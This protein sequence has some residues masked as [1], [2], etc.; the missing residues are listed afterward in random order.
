[1]QVG[2]NLR[3]AGVGEESAAL[4]SAPDGGGVRTFGIG[5]QIVHVAIAAG[6]QNDGVGDMRLHLAGDE[7]ARDDAARDAIH[8]DEVEHF[9]TREH[10]D[11]ARVDLPF[12]S[13]IGAERSCWPVWPRA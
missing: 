6:G 7:I 4:I 3:E 1:M 5:G 8:D 12:E 11:G 10:G 13:L 2:V 9:G